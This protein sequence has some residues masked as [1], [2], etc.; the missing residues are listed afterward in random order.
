MAIYNTWV[1]FIFQ[2]EYVC[3]YSFSWLAWHVMWYQCIFCSC[4]LKFKTFQTP[5]NGVSIS[6]LI[7][8]QCTDSLANNLIFLNSYGWCVAVQGIFAVMK[9]VLQFFYLS[10]L[11]QLWLLCHFEMASMAVFHFD[12]YSCWCQANYHIHYDIC[13]TCMPNVFYHL[14]MHFWMSVQDI[15]SV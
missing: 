13:L 2:H 15:S 8:T 7:W 12:I 4:S 9:L 5:Y 6:L 1:C 10:S 14:S 11:C 3:T